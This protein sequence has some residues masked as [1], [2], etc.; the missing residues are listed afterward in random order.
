M[1]SVAAARLARAKQHMSDARFAAERAT[2]ADAGPHALTCLDR[3]CDAVDL[4]IEIEAERALGWAPVP[5]EV[6]PCID[7]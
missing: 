5:E 6:M 2:S 3:L 4:L 7:L 1:L